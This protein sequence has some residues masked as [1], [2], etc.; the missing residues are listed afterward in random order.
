MLNMYALYII[1]GQME[2][3]LGKTRYVIVYILSGL[4]GNLFSLIFDNYIVMLYIEEL[5][6]KLFPFNNLVV[7]CLSNFNFF[8]F[9]INLS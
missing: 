9:S 7:S 4:V 3:Y 5:L 6:S 8:S 1:G 2:S